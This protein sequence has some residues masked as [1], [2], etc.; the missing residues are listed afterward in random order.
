MSTEIETTQDRGTAMMTMRM[1]KGSAAR[2]PPRAPGADTLGRTTSRRSPRHTRTQGLLRGSTLCQLRDH[3]GESLGSTGLT[4]W[5]Q[6]A[7]EE[8]E[9][10][11]GLVVNE[12][13]MHHRAL[14]NDVT[15]LHLSAGVHVVDDGIFEIHGAILFSPPASVSTSRTHAGPQ[16]RRDAD[17]RAFAPVHLPIA[18]RPWC[19]HPWSADIASG[20]KELSEAHAAVGAVV[21]CTR[22]PRRGRCTCRH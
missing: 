9:S 4:R 16:V 12:R 21:N 6:T 8:T 14:S 18:T 1:T 2:R 10:V 13:H 3:V 5:H 11:S 19:S 17:I 7:A 15:H 22:A 20:S